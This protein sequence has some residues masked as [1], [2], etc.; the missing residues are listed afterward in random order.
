MVTDVFRVNAQIAP[1]PVTGTPMCV[2]LGRVKTPR[3]GPAGPLVPEIAPNL[4]AVLSN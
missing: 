1:D 2:P 3:R 4:A